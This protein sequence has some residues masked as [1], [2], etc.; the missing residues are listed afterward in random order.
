MISKPDSAEAA[1]RD[2]AKGVL[3]SSGPRLSVLRLQDEDA[4]VR[5][6]AEVAAGL[7]GHPRCIPS[8]YFYDAAGSAL[9]EQITALDAYYPTRT[10]AAILRRIAP[11]LARMLGNPE[12]VELGSGSST[13]TRFLLEAF[14]AHRRTITYVPIDVSHT[15]LFETANQLVRDYP[16]LRVMGM[17]G[18]FEEAL[19]VLPPSSQRLVLFLG[20]TLGN[21]TP[22]YQEAFFERL[23]ES[24]APG[25]HL[26][27]G[28][29]RRPHSRKPESRILAAYN[30]AS[31]ITA[32]FNLNLL[33][34]LNRELGADFRLEAWSH[35]AQY[36]PHDHQIEMYLESREAQEVNIEALGLT[37]AF[38]A[39]ERLLTEIS[40]KFYPSE[41]VNWF[42]ERG[43]RA[44]QHWSD[45]RQDFSLLLFERGGF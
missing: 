37:F 38:E 34:R 44:I 24:L 36:N 21:F 18:Q 12:I 10:E 8:T 5:M 17:A 26:L 28:F 19:E 30:D 23:G 1:R 2:A 15:M 3:S 9:Y 33:E 41:L 13:K 31:G 25:S 35:V 11:E 6:R 40:R 27:L 14:A 32:R 20:G 45:E 16:D 39:Q 42:E 22:R 4:G 43:F 7:S 29:D